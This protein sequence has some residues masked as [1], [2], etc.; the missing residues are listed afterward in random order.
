MLDGPVPQVQN[1]PGSP[2]PEVTMEQDQDANASVTPDEVKR[3]QELN[4]EMSREY[5]DFHDWVCSSLEIY[6]HELFLLSFP[7]FVHLYL[8][9]MGHGKGSRAR[10]DSN[11][12]TD[13]Q[14]VN[15]PTSLSLQMLGQMES[16]ASSFFQRCAADH[17]L[18]NRDEVRYLSSIRT[19]RHV[20][21]ACDSKTREKTD[22]QEYVQDVLE[23]GNQFYVCLSQ[24]AMRLLSNHLNER[25]YMFVAG[26]INERVH[27]EICPDMIQD[28]KEYSRAAG[29]STF[30]KNLTISALRSQN[31]RTQLKNALAEKESTKT[32]NEL[33]WGTLPVK[34]PIRLA[35][36][37]AAVLDSESASGAISNTKDSVGEQSSSTAGASSTSSDKVNDKQAGP[38]KASG[39]SK[40]GSNKQAGANKASP[41]KNNKQVQKVKQKS[42]EYRNEQDLHGPLP[43]NFFSKDGFNNPHLQKVN[44]VFFFMLNLTP[45]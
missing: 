9:I 30:R 14:L 36:K 2:T 11:V 20:D 42:F 22:A 33:G 35:K 26:V 12:E 32:K 21:E 39:S 27:V 41:N 24:F 5:E 44:Q 23:K 16:D 15:N 10:R 1:P 34:I 8:K 4:A 19:K 31:F 29:L 38:N 37:K 7:V 25:V 43:D 3:I 45:I 6:K 28:L 40:V 17:N 13:V 18:L